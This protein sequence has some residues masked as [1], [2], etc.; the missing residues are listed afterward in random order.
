MK[1]PGVRENS[2]Q[3]DD[4]LIYRSL[5]HSDPEGYDHAVDIWALGIIS[6]ILLC[7]FHPFREVLQEELVPQFLQNK[8][9]WRAFQSALSESC[10]KVL[11]EQGDDR[12]RN[13]MVS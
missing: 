11:R 6:Y 10:G 3:S 13:M 4:N 8:Q 1:R 9:V 5:S 7:G 2:F 12:E